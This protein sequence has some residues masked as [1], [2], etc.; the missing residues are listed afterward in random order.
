M[1]ERQRTAL[2]I[3]CIICAFAATSLAAA[4]LGLLLRLIVSAIGGGR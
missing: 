4:V 1:T 2:F 3:A